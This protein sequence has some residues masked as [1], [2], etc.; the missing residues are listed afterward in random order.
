MNDFIVLSLLGGTLALD[1]RA[2]WQSLLS[3]PVFAAVAV[4]YLIGE[5]ESAAIVG[6]VLELVW[7]SI[8]PMRGVRRPDQ[9]AGAIIGAGTAGLLCKHTGDPRLVF[10]TGLGVFFGLVAAEISA[11]LGAPAFRS[12]DR[13]LGRTRFSEEADRRAIV[14]RLSRLHLV[15][16]SYIFAVEMV[17][18]LILL[19]PSYHVA[20]KLSLNV[21]GTFVDGVVAWRFLMP[22][23]GVASLIHFYWQRHL[24]RML[25]LSAVLVF[26]ILWIH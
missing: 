9:I 17:L 11:R 21:A 25:V 19:P 13:F 1:E 8:L 15:S 7:M 10:L 22:A 6:L 12:L 23:I 16:A 14:K 26:I 5:L 24:K 18:V 3:N 4:G 20:E 2:G